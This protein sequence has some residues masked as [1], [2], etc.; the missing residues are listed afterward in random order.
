MDRY[1]T[2]QVGA[3][4]HTEWWVPAEELDALNDQIVGTIEV[5]KTF[6]TEPPKDEAKQQEHKHEQAEYPKL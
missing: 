1:A 6:R 3:T 2:Q 4:H 5:V